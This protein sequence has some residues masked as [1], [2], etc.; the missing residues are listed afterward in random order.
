MQLWDELI[1]RIVTKD[2]PRNLY[3]YDLWKYSVVIKRPYINIGQEKV[4][5]LYAN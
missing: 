4:R 2:I 5:N 3:L 1:A